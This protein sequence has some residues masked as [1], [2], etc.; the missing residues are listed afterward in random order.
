MYRGLYFKII[1][2]LV[3]FT[4]IV[5][6][7]VGAVLIS[8]VL[9]YYNDQFAACMTQ[10]FGEDAQLRQYLM[11][12][13]TDADGD[14][15]AKQKSILASYASRLGIDDYRNYYILD[16]DGNF[17]N[18]SDTAGG[19]A[20]AETPNLVA[21]MNGQLGDANTAGSD[22]A[23]YA[24]PLTVGDASCIIYLR[25][26]QDELHEI[27][28]MLFSI[29]L[30]ALFIGLLIAILLSFFL[31]RAI[32]MPLS[33][34]TEGV[35]RVAKGDFKDKISVHSAD[36]IG[37]LTE[38]FNTMS[39]MLE[40]NLDEI[41]GEREK[42]ETVLSCLKDAVITFGK[43]GRPLQINRAATDLFADAKREELTL[44]YIFSL[45]HY[46][47]GGIDI[48]L[49]D[50]SGG[51]VPAVRYKGRVYEL[52]FGN[53][54]YRDASSMRE[55]VILVIH[56]VTQSYELDRSRREFVANASHE[57]RTP[58]TTIKMVIE[59]LAGDEGVTKN[60]MNKSF[61][62]MAET[63]STRM[64]LLIKN[65]LTLSQL[66]SKTMNF[67]VREF[68]LEESVAY[69]AKS[70]AVNASAHGHKLTFDGAYDPVI[71]RGDKIRI[72]QI[73]IN[74]TS[75]AIK[76]T[77][78]GGRISLRLHDLGDRAEITI[79][80]NG[81]GIPEEDI[82]HLFERFYR[83]EK[84]RS[85]DKGGTGLGLAIAKEFAVAHGGDIRVSSIV[86]KG[87]T[88]T[89]TLPKQGKL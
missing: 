19:E 36:E 48:S 4:L 72:E 57:L 58:L 26:T 76:Y 53:I 32:S 77:P 39:R 24:L 7:V 14:F 15:A 6:S 62:D 51:D 27:N 82:P 40:E 56:D 42:L 64:E 55:G 85:S 86:G 78:D 35:Q 81:V 46:E 83:V 30:Q 9:G 25:D 31:A 16:A 89:V 47:S 37:V 80:D 2:I 79:T 52:Y 23:D 38:N 20:L 5:M 60:E 41:N 10:N 12:A 11:A 17:L 45:L 69:L 22:Y 87:T 3:I 49:D 84:A 21:A 13:M 43:D 50:E 1:L 65:L 59:A 70:L 74:I 54:R 73:L 68:D 44:D 29:I 28:W 8:S 75:N 67:N 71:I 63:E 61:L 34:L 18:G 66:D 33:R 88:F